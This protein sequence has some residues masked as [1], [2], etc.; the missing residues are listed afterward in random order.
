MKTKKIK[1]FGE[2]SRKLFFLPR[3]IGKVLTAETVSAFRPF[4]QSFRAR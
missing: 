4:Y 2:I 1:K 3:K